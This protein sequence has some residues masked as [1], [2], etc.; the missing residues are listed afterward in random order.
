MYDKFTDRARKVM[1]LANQEAQRFNHEYIGTEHIL[2]GMIKEG[3]GVAAFALKNLSVDLRRIRLQVESLITAGPDM[4]TM[5][6][7]PQTPRA[8]KVVEN[9]IEEATKLNHSYVGTEHLL[10][11]LIREEEGVAAQALRNIGVSLESVR[12]EVLSLLAGKREVRQTAFA[13]LKNVNLL[14]MVHRLPEIQPPLC[15]GVLTIAGASMWNGREW[16]SL[17]SHPPKPITSHKIRWWTHI[18]YSEIEKK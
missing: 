13:G 9:A 12:N 10:M 8:R 16:V 6:K 7:L 15:E 17:L 4:V 14:V 11:G 5:G 2:L 1:Q 3:N 18:P